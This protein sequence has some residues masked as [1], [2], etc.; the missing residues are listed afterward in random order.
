MIYD[1][2]SNIVVYEGSYR[3]VRVDGSMSDDYS[4]FDSIIRTAQ[5][6]VFQ[7][8]EVVKAKRKLL[9][10]TLDESDTSVTNTDPMTP[11]NSVEDQEYAKAKAE[12][13]SLP[14]WNYWRPQVEVRYLPNW[15]VY[16]KKN[17]IPIELQDR[18]NIKCRLETVAESTPVDIQA[19]PS[20]GTTGNKGDKGD[21]NVATSAHINQDGVKKERCYY[22]PVI[23]VDYFWSLRSSYI[24]INSTTSH[25][26]LHISITPVSLWA[27]RFTRSMDPEFTKKHNPALM[28]YLEQSK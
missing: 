4:P 3:G 17:P 6:N 25:L 16:S 8:R 18:V 22:E 5:V 26:P 13:L 15:D 24:H 1:L 2:L 10:N 19:V 27:V 14:F 21:T 11:G 28:Q 7:P 9:G 20:K 23:Y 12:A